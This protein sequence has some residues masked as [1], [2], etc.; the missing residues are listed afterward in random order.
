MRLDKEKVVHIC[1][2]AIQKIYMYF[3]LFVLILYWLTKQRR[4]YLKTHKNCKAL[5]KLRIRSQKKPTC[6][7]SCKNSTSGKKLS[8]S[9]F[10]LKYKLK[11]GTIMEIPEQKEYSK[12]IYFRCHER[13]NLFKGHSA[14]LSL[15]LCPKHFTAIL[16]KVQNM[17]SLR[18]NQYH[19]FHEQWHNVKVW[20]ANIGD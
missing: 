2:T 5:S 7:S 15:G 9:F 1:S 4:P 8:I 17:N 16:W 11:P 6:N 19:A 10:V 13:P 20:H 3:T 14:F 12:L 18:Y